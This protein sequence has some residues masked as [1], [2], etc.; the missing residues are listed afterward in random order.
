MVLAVF[1]LTLYPVLSNT[2]NRSSLARM[3]EKPTSLQTIPENQ[4]LE[5]ISQPEPMPAIAEVVA[6][7]YRRQWIGQAWGDLCAMS[8]GEITFSGINGRCSTVNNNRAVYRW[9]LTGAEPFAGWVIRCGCPDLFHLRSLSCARE[10]RSKTTCGDGAT[11]TR[12]RR[13]ITYFGRRQKRNPTIRGKGAERCQVT[14]GG[15]KPAKQLHRF[16]E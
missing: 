15:D 1:C 2:T 5:R 7:A 12:C 6:P 13:T 3:N 11:E 8:R 9:R 16:M 4:S 14:P 10:A